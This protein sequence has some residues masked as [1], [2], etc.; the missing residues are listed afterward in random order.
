MN[1]EDKLLIKSLIFAAGFVFALLSLISLVLTSSDFNAAQAGDSTLASA[2]LTPLLLVF[3][4]VAIATLIIVI[5]CFA[6]TFMSSEKAKA[7]LRFLPK[8]AYRLAPCH[9]TP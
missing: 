5:A 6:L 2:N 4:I 1:K 8:L 7:A 3:F 9:A